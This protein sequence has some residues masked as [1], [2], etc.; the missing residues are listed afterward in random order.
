[1][2]LGRLRLLCTIM[3]GT[4]Y[5]Y[6]TFNRKWYLSNDVIAS[7]SKVTGD[8]VKNVFPFPEVEP[9]LATCSERFSLH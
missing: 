5:T 4:T 1:M 6:P 8:I 9:S 2:K 3:F 7:I